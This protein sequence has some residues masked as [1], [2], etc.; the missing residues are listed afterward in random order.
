MGLLSSLNDDRIDFI[1]FA[2]LAVGWLDTYDM[3]DLNEMVADWLID[4]NSI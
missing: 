1:D 2:L 3:N 4:C